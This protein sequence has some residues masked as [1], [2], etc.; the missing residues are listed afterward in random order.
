MAKKTFRVFTL[1]GAGKD[2]NSSKTFAPPRLGGEKIFAFLVILAFLAV[3]I[4]LKFT[5]H[6]DFE[7]AHL[8]AGRWLIIVSGRAILEVLRISGRPRDE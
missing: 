6:P 5:K 8:C 2:T 7:K 4:P 1:G 3:N